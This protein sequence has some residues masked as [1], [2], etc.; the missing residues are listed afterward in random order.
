MRWS[1]LC[2]ASVCPDAKS[3]STQVRAGTTGGLARGA[4]AGGGAAA[5]TPQAVL[6]DAAWLRQ[7]GASTKRT[8][9]ATNRLRLDFISRSPG[10]G[11]LATA[12]QRA[13][14]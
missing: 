12:V 1:A 2:S 13:A 5:G 4:V 9:M 3:I 8:V 10:T 11:W 14:V 6:Q 7:R